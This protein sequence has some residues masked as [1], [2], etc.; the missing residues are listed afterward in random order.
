MTG[1]IWPECHLPMGGLVEIETSIREAIETPA[2][3][4]IG[5]IAKRV[6]RAAT[7]ESESDRVAS[8]AALHGELAPFMPRIGIGPT[9]RSD[10]VAIDLHNVIVDIIDGLPLRQCANESCERYFLRQRGTAQ[11]GQY[12]SKGVLYCSQRCA[13]RQAQRV[14]RRRDRE[15]ILMEASE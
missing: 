15:Q 2:Y 12:R 9:S 14:K 6:I 11:H 7:I 8:L 13:V 3:F 10:A 1:D 4:N 5:R